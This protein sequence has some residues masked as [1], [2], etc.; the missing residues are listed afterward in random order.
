MRYAAVIICLAIT[1]LAVGCE[2][3]S[4]LL[5]PAGDCIYCP[6]C[7]T[8]LFLRLWGTSRTSFSKTEYIPLVFDIDIPLIMRE[9]NCPVCGEQFVDRDEN[10]KVVKIYYHRYQVDG[11]DWGYDG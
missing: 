9:F 3:E 10:G 4:Q 11:R 7:R 2:H 8:N 6:E 1:L 5:P